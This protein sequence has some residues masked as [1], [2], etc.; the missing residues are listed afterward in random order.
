MTRKAWFCFESV[1]GKWSPVIYYDEEPSKEYHRSVFEKEHTPYILIPA[2]FIAGDEVFVSFHELQSMLQIPTPPPTL[3]I[4]E[5]VMVRPVEGYI[6]SQGQYFDTEA[7]ATLY[8]A[9]FDL[10]NAFHKAIVAFSLEQNQALPTETVETAVSLILDVLKAEH[11]TAIKYLTAVGTVSR[12]DAVGGHSASD[13]PQDVQ[14]ISSVPGESMDESAA[15]KDEFAPD[16]SLVE[17]PAL[18]QQHKSSKR[19]K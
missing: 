9:G 6:T 2:E 19:R 10:R 13:T 14:S 12:A 8:E 15:A 16:G 18:Q 5:P 17:Q 1:F 3:P 11:E 7:K 4:E